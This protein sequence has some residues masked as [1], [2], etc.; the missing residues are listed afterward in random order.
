[1]NIKLSELIIIPIVIALVWVGFRWYRQPGVTSGTPAPEFAGQLASGDSLRLSD[2]RGQ[3]V[4]LDFWGSWCAPCRQSN[5]QLRRLYD[6][7]HGAKFTKGEDFTILSV[8]IETSKEAWLAAIEKDGLIWPHHVSD[9]SRFNDH[10]AA[11]YGI[12]EVPTTILVNPD[13]HILGINMDYDNVNA[14]LS[15]FLVKEEAQ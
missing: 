9:L 8:G 11:L 2:L 14:Q 12:K 15:R 6:R 10:V 7:Y 4:L 1:M 3:W 13:G 5:P